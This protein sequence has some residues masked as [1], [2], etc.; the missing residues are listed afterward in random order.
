MLLIVL[1]PFEMVVTWVEVVLNVNAWAN[2]STHRFAV[3]NR[4][5]LHW[6]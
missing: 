6:I 5:I 3:G 2:Y 1:S 4:G